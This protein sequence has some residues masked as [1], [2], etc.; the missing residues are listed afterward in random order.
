VL[1]V[2]KTGGD[3]VA[4]ATGEVNPDRIVVDDEAINWSNDDYGF[5]EM[6]PMA[7]YWVGGPAL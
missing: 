5:A 2:A 7:L 1:R 4:I 6:P 3:P